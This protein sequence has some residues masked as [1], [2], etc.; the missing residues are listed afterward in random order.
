MISTVNKSTRNFNWS[1]VLKRGS[2][3]LIVINKI[4]QVSPKKGVAKW[5]EEVIWLTVINEIFKRERK[6]FSKL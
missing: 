2:K 5:T 3:W 1:H 6:K 4:W